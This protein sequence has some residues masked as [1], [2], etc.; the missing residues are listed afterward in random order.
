MKLK[1]YSYLLV[2]LLMLLIGTND[3]YASQSKWCYYASDDF[4]FKAR[5]EMIWDVYE[6]SD[7]CVKMNDACMGFSAL[8]IQTWIIEIA[9][10][11]TEVYI[12]RLPGYGMT[13]DGTDN[14]INWTLDRTRNCIMGCPFYF[15]TR[16][17]NLDI[18][19]SQKDET[20]CPQFLVYD[21]VKWTIG[22]MEDYTLVTDNEDEAKKAQAKAKYNVSYGKLVDGTTYYNDG[23]VEEEPEPEPELEPCE[24]YELIFGDPADDGASNDPNGDRKPS[25]RY[26]LAMILQYV[27]IIV[28]ILIILLGTIDFAKAVLSGKEDNMKKAQKTFAMRI[29]IGVAVFFVP[30]LVNLV[31]DLAEIVWAGQYTHCDF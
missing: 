25:I 21:Y 19:N 16:Y 23:K 30:L 6:W 24:E 28:P 1:K 8:D 10:Y 13:H 22:G 14:V 11:M 2:F 29:L 18:A 15:D 3:V 5:L 7:D 26:Y 12:D 4:K 27:R 31:M 9:D 20:N 17:E